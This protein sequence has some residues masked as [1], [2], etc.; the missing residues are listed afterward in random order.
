MK[1]RLL[2][3]FVIA[4]ALTVAAIPQASQA[5]T[6]SLFP[7]EVPNGVA[8]AAGEQ[9]HQRIDLTLTGSPVANSRMVT[10]T[11]PGE[12]TYVPN[13]ATVA[14]NLSTIR[15]FFAGLKS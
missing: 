14:S 9:Y 1:P 5:Q 3:F 10:V 11:L 2:C 4:L 12:L 7:D 13:S 8:S 6:I 15:G